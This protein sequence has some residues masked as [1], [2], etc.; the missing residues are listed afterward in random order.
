M[1][2]LTWNTQ[3]INITG[4]F[5]SN[6]ANKFASDKFTK[7]FVPEVLFLQEA[8]NAEYAGCLDNTLYPCSWNPKPS[9]Q[10]YQLIE[11]LKL[12]R[13]PYS[14]VHVAWQASLQGNERCSMAILWRND[15]YTRSGLG[16]WHD[17]KETHR[18][19]FWVELKTAL[20]AP[21]G[22]FA[23]IHAPSSASFTISKSYIDTAVEALQD[24]AKGGFG[25]QYIL[26]GDFNVEAS[27]LEQHLGNGLTLLAPA[28]M[29]QKSGGILDYLIRPTNWTPVNDAAASTNLV[30]S[31]HAQVR[32]IG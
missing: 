4:S 25:D 17:G 6:I 7:A 30:S 27:E 13:V 9:F 2:F 26:C 31:D 20:Q 10:G 24:A 18:P 16:G 29:T 19:V 21:V 23:C 22:V 1:Q 12:S 32:F 14:G 8:G 3:G 11:G 15:R 5:L 28:T